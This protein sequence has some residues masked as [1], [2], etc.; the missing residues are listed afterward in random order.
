MLR[1]DVAALDAAKQ[2]ELHM[3]TSPVKQQNEKT[4]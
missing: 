4:K 2:L 3:T 1:L